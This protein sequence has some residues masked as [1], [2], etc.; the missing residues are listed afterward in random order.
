M[1]AILFLIPLAILSLQS[2]KEVISKNITTLTPVLIT[3]VAHDTIAVNPV[4]F[5]WEVM[6]GA[7]KYRLQIARPSFSNI[8]DLVLDSMI[9]GTSFYLDLDDSSQYELKLTAYNSGYQS[10]TLGPILFHVGTAPI[11]NPVGSELNFISPSPA[12]NAIIAYNETSTIFKWNPLTSATNYEFTL[13]KGA[14]FD[15]GTLISYKSGSSETVTLLPADN[16]KVPGVFW[17]RVTA[18]NGTNFLTQKINSFTVDTLP[19][20]VPV[21]VSPVDASNSIT[22]ADSTTFDWT[23]TAQDPINQSPLPNVYELEISAFNTFTTLLITK[24]TP[25]TSVTLKLPI[26]FVAGTYYWRVRSKDGLNN[27]SLY[28]S[29]IFSFIIQ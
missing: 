25:E 5:T 19:P 6:D 11:T 16:P 17:W 2:C 7:T 27:T 8:S 9:I 1:K 29:P 28:S 14:S 24:S 18:Y 21:L 13:K 3:P 26:A 10:Q 22:V 20:P 23:V 15:V 12:N 4:H